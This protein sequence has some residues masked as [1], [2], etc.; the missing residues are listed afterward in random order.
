MMM[1][2]FNNKKYFYSFNK[3]PVASIFSY[4][5]T[6]THTCFIFHCHLTQLLRRCRNRHFTAHYQKKNHLKLFFS[7]FINLI[8]VNATQIFPFISH[9]EN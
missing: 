6:Q 2:P 4:K 9:F 3:T 7:I 5:P 1:T 8:I